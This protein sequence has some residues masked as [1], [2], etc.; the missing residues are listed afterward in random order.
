[1]NKD[2]KLKYDLI[3]SCIKIQSLLRYFSARLKFLNA[4]YGCILIQTIW[5]GYNVRKNL[6]NLFD[7]FGN[8]DD[9]WIH[10]TKKL[11]YFKITKNK[12]MILYLDLKINYINKPWINNSGNNYM[13]ENIQLNL[14][15]NNDNDSYNS[16]VSSN[17]KI[18]DNILLDI[19]SKDKEIQELKKFILNLREQ[20]KM[21]ENHYEDRIKFY[22]EQQNK[23][24]N[25]MKVEREAI[26]EDNRVMTERILAD[27]QEE[28]NRRE[29]TIEQYQQIMADEEARFRKE[30]EYR[31]VEK[32]KLLAEMN[33]ITSKQESMMS[34][35]KMS[36]QA[37]QY[38]SEV[39][40]T[41]QIK[42]VTFADEDDTSSNDP[43]GNYIDSS[44]NQIKKSYKKVSYRE[45]ENEIMNDY[46]DNDVN[47][48]TALDI[49]ATYLRGQKLIYMESKAFCESRLNK[50]MMPS[51]FLSTAATV[52]AAIVKDFFWG[53]Y[54]IAGVNGIIA[55]LLA[56]V[57][58]LKLDAASEAHKISAHQYDKLQTKIEFLSGKVLLFK[59]QIIDSTFE[60][61]KKQKEIEEN[62]ESEIQ[63]QI[64]E[65][66]K[67]I[68]EI[69]ETNQFLVPKKIRT[70]YPLIYNTNVFVIIKKLDDNRKRKINSIKD[71]KNR[72]NYLIEVL[73]S[74][75]AKDP[76]D[77]SI[78]KIE[79]E[80]VR[81]QS[82]KERHINNILII[83][84][85]FS[86]ID[87]MFAKEVENAEKLKKMRVRR[88][89]FCG[90]GIDEKITDPTEI[91]SYIN[92]I[93]KPYVTKTENIPVKKNNTD[94]LD[95]LIND[96]MTTNKFL[97]DKQKDEHNKR[98]KTISN[99][100]KANIILQKNM[101]LTNQICD[102]M[103]IYDKLEKGE[104]K[105]S[106]ETKIENKEH[107]E[108]KEQTEDIIKLK[109]I[110]NIHR[111]F[112]DDEEIKLEIN[113]DSANERGSISGSDD[114]NPF[115][116]TDVCKDDKEE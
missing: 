50:L 89:L 62:N 30:I 2:T 97:K 36:R 22:E 77:K 105:L 26:L 11:N 81:L 37:Y 70:T 102:K 33:E 55:F 115:I 103:E 16:L 12:L 106:N 82:E 52:L 83:K 78:T 86:I 111:L 60:A 5:R 10:Y 6:N 14:E 99:L 42:G 34:Q 61:Y 45:V 53:A 18:S 73:K 38:S 100:R 19:D 9:N 90:Y 27:N 43:S 59:S 46:F 44:G 25:N 112:S 57:N 17:S 108:T 66:K 68:E 3:D 54:L 91:N 15:P 31:E 21:I 75:R 87:E 64:D 110:K 56:I 47:Y 79:N 80:L 109:K 92:E 116:D 93:M 7:N 8:Y 41:P 104:L 94:S 71:V 49:I 39:A 85:A 23:I 20:E 74:K 98:R 96:L 69:K 48:S 114:E 72:R 24:T 107:V 1:M 95:D 4:K 13:E 67:K 35:H 32:Q 88:W 65:V 51:I 76:T 28:I 40:T 101:Q 63:T 84:S 58:Y 29:K 113:Y